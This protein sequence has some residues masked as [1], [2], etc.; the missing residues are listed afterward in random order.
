MKNKRRIASILTILMFGCVTCCT[1]PAWADDYSYTVTVS[2]GVQGTASKSVQVKYGDTV[3]ISPDDVTI[4]ND[5]YYLKGFH[6]SGQES[7]VVQAGDITGIQEDLDLVATYGIKQK[8]V[9]YT[10][11]YVDENNQDLLSAKTFYGNVGDKPVLAFTMIEGFSPDAY[12]LT[13][14]LKDNEA[15]N[16]F[17]FSY[18]SN[19]GGEAAETPVNASENAD[20][21]AEENGNDSDG[22][23]AGNNNRAAGNIFAGN[24]GGNDGTGDTANAG[25]NEGPG[26]VDLDD[27]EVAKADGSGTNAEDGNNGINAGVIAGSIVGALIL[28]ALI[29]LFMRRR[30]A[31]DQ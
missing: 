12:A 17:V 5:K 15:E 18:T 1:V 26:I 3:T 28:A 27:A 8:M 29:A 30:K 7:P 31:E 22:D 11:R 4:K 24:A 10:V 20:Q 9:K 21:N 16:V 25:N 23:N 14:T 6:V 2:G 13:K 19:P